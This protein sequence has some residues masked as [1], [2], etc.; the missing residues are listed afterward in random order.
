VHALIGLLSPVVKEKREHKQRYR[1]I[2]NDLVNVEAK[3]ATLRRD[4][5][6][7]E[8]PLADKTKLGVEIQRIVAKDPT[9]LTIK[10]HK[11]MRSREVKC[12]GAGYAINAV[13]IEI[14]REGRHAR[15]GISYVPN[16][17]MEGYLDQL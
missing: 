14:H 13:K 12:R 1:R 9:N 17:F 8:E 6:E 15:M 5:A 10:V 11:I 16:V 3:I 7:F 4:I 2:S